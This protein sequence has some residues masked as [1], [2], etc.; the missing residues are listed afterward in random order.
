MMVLGEKI[1]I[2]RKEIGMSAEELAA[3]VG[4][5]PTTIYR[6][7]NGDISKVSTKKVGEMAKALRISPAFLI[8]LEEEHPAAE[9][10][11]HKPVLSKQDIDAIAERVHN[12]DKAP[13][14]QAPRTVE[15]R[16]VSFGMDHLP[17]ADRERILAMI[18]A[19]FINKPESQLFDEK[20]DKNET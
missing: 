14:D 5:S 12:Y 20:G 9:E 6:Y 10:P 7:E 4:L 19:M 3:Q 8:G 16:I 13:Q 11:A 2:R 1:K 17:A 15:A 18:R